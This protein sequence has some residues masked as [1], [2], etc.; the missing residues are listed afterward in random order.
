MIEIKGL[1]KEFNTDAGILTVLD[2]IN[3]NVEQ[4]DIF[5]VIGMSGAGKST[6]I[7]CINL[8]E[9]PT[10][11]SIKIDGTEITTLRQSELDTLRKNI[12]MIFQNFNLLMQKNVSRNIAFGLEIIKVKDYECEGMT[13]EEYDQLSYFQKRKARKK[14]IQET[15]NRLLKIVELEDKAKSYPSQLSGGQKQRVAIA[16]ALATNPKILLCDEATSALDTMTTSSILNLLKK[17]NEERGVTIVIITHEMDVVEKVCNKVAVL[18]QARVVE[19]GDVKSILFDSA[20]S[21]TKNLV[22]GSNEWKQS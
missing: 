8:L 12:G 3:I 18:D 10:K 14:D 5:G 17:I 15:V 21:V 13:K 1:T 11:G 7:R 20:S 19:Q 16:R 6:L 4:G 9:K 2:D 22:G